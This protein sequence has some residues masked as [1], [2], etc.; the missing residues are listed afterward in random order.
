MI[1]GELKVIKNLIIA[2]TDKEYV[3]RLSAY[4]LKTYGNDYEIE[5]F[6]DKS[7]L[8][9]RIQQ[10]RCEVLLLSPQLYDS[11]IYLKNIKLPII[12]IDD[13][14]LVPYPDKFKWTINKYTRISKLLHYMNKEYEKVEKNR[15]I[16]YSFYGPAGGVGKTTMALAAAMAY[17]KV[18]RKVL[19]INLEEMD[20]TGMFFEEKDSTPKEVLEHPIEDA[21]DQILAE[22]IKQYEHT[23]IMYL[24][25]NYI[26]DKKQGNAQVDLLVERAIDSGIANIVMIDLSASYSQ[27]YEVFAGISDYVVLVSNAHTHA[28]YKLTQLLRETKLVEEFGEKLKLIVNQSKEL[29]ISTEIDVIGRI[30][31]LYATNP[32]GLCEYIAQNQFLKLHGLA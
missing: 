18:G 29:S 5:L 10:R 22:R 30:D 3:A 11:Q 31:K 8:K 32:L 4:I 1:R 20:S 26:E 25:R 15:P 16:I 6:Y 14:Q 19:Y 21:Y 28:I 9:E 2:D 23:P 13:D 12:L 24:K 7:K 27:L 17:A